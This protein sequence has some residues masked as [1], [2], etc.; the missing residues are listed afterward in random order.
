MTELIEGL[1]VQRERRARLMPDLYA[2][3]THPNTGASEA[4]I[5]AAEARVGRPLDPTYRQL[6]RVADGWEE[7]DGDR[8]L[9]GTA[10]IGRSNA[11]RSAMEMIEIYSSEGAEPL[12]GW[13]ADLADAFPVCE[14][15]ANTAFVVMADGP[16]HIAGQVRDFSSGSNDVF[17][18]VETWLRH[19]LAAETDYL[20][21]ESFGPHGRAWRQVVTADS[22]SVPEIVA[23]LVELRHALRPIEQAWVP[24]GPDPR[25]G[26]TPENLDALERDCGLTL[27]ADHRQLLLIADGWTGIGRNE[28]L[29]SVAEIR[30]GTRWRDAVAKASAA[31]RR[32]EEAGGKPLSV[33]PEVIPF[34]VSD[35]FE[36]GD[37]VIGTD[38]SGRCFPSPTDIEP[39]Q[40]S[41]VREHLLHLVDRA[42]E[43][44]N[45]ARAGDSERVPR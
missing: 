26:A 1:I 8:N 2:P 17:R 33:Y 22:P 36:A 43:A 14:Y 3:P 28:D 25:P 35:E 32:I 39:E 9:L 6:L 41:T 29:L 13:P 15:Y 38:S 19:Q 40:L 42:N 18:N 16:D 37:W 34:S 45:I 5:A 30:A 4:D 44:L 21:G 11:W 24:A 23:K 31:A 10:D 7:Y 12:F 20:D 27:S